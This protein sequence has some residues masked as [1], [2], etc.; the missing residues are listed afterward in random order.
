MPP[1]AKKAAAHEKAINTSLHSN[2]V[3]L[4]LPGR[5]IL[6]PKTSLPNLAAQASVGANGTHA[7]SPAS[8]PFVDSAPFVLDAADDSSTAATGQLNGHAVFNHDRNMG[9]T[10]SLP[11]RG[12]GV[13]YSLDSDMDDSSHVVNGFD[14]HVPYNHATPLRIDVNASAAASRQA[15]ANSKTTF[16]GFTTILKAHPLLDVIVLLIFLLQFP[17]AVVGFIHFIFTCMTFRATPPTAPFNTVPSFADVFF[18]NAGNASIST[19]VLVDVL[20][21]VIFAFLW[22]QAQNVIIDLAHA[23]IAISLGGAAS[24]RGGTTSSAVCCLSVIT[25]SH[26]ARSRT[27]QQLGVNVLW[28]ELIRR[29][30]LT[31]TPPPQLSDGLDRLWATRGWKTKLLGVHILAQGV[32][33]MVRRY[34]YWSKSLEDD[35]AYYKK[36]DPEP[37]D[38]PASA[39]PRPVR[40]S[41]D[42]RSDVAFSSSSDVRHTGPSPSH[43][44]ERSSAKR[45]KRMSTQVKIQQPFW[46]A[47]ASAKINARKDSEKTFAKVDASAAKTGTGSHMGSVDFSSLLERV[48]IMEVGS[49][50]ISFGVCLPLVLGEAEQSRPDGVYVKV[51]GAMWP[52][53]KKKVTESS[54]VEAGVE[55]TTWE[56]RVYGLTPL[57]TYHCEFWK[58]SNNDLV[59]QTTL[60]T[61]PAPS[62]EIGEHIRAGHALANVPAAIPTPPA[63]LQPSS[64]ATTLRNSIQAEE[65]D[66][67]KS[68]NRLKAVRKQ[69]KNTLDR[70]VSQTEKE[71]ARLSKDGGTDERQRQRAKQLE[72]SIQ[73]VKCETKDSEDSL[74]ELRHMPVED[75]ELYAEAKSEA[76]DRQK[77]LDSQKGQH[78]RAKRIADKDYAVGKGDIDSILHKR[79]RFDSR[80]KELATKLVDARKKRDNGAQS[81]SKKSKDSRDRD[82]A[83][84]TQQLTLENHIGELERQLAESQKNQVD[85][86][87]QVQQFEEW[88]NLQAAGASAPATPEGVSAMPAL[89][90]NPAALLS[91][92]GVSSSL[93]GSR[94]SSLHVN[95]SNQVPAFQFPAPTSMNSGA[96]M[97]GL[98]LQS[99]RRASSLEVES[100]PSLY[101]NAFVGSGLAAAATAAGAPYSSSTASSAALLANSTALSPAPGGFGGPILGLANGHGHGHGHGQYS[102]GPLVLPAPVGAEKYRSRR[103]SSS[104]GGSRGSISGPGGPIGTSNSNGSISA[105]AG[106]GLNSTAGGNH[107]NVNGSPR[108]GGTAGMKLNVN[109]NGLSSTPSPPIWERRLNG[110]GAAERK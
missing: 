63:T 52:S 73:K 51:N 108:F 5:R 45:K 49:T 92:I 28:P 58:E 68:R 23:V 3:G 21:G 99:R 44:K 76:R 85:I 83:R 46:A 25:V 82:G 30:L 64:P 84:R 91:S 74:E 8:S 2:N 86:L 102:P 101:Q 81:Q 53:V 61:Q 98:P 107:A 100:F 87:H 31:D 11:C 16:A 55:F 10:Q 96:G 24:S 39:T 13:S 9:T 72:N 77:R 37:T 50:E 57:S 4:A 71:N 79:S 18:G 1:R 65:V 104:S 75:K 80:Q 90:F 47:L 33:R 62:T 7:A 106:I 32:M 19:I 95:S 97:N 89:G 35:P 40:S 110:I 94:P 14:G 15:R 105:L 54:T 56:C 93:P 17:P 36:V 88:S 59:Y 109:T 67:D 26:L 66:C 20:A 34:L 48:W 12:R 69:H 38:S 6:K 70:I 41:P 60:I 103:K 42:L 78:D 29:G 43:H 27:I 22:P